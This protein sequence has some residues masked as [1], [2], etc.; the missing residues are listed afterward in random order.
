MLYLLGGPPRA[1]KTKIADAYGRARG[2]GWMSFDIVRSVARSVSVDLGRVEVNVGSDPRIESEAMRPTFELVT[3][4][5]SR[6]ASNY[7]VEGVAFMPRHVAGLPN[8][9]ERR[10]CF[11]GLSSVTLQDIDEHAGG[12]DWHRGL[13]PYEA[14]RLPAWI[15]EW[16][17]IIRED[18][19]EHGLSFVDLSPDWDTGAARVQRVFDAG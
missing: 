7:L 16:S 11:V 15:I 14:A 4:M 19:E 8:S 18:C 1:G 10:A 9:I 3:R 2:V 13:A 17:N 6:L 12:N 5:S